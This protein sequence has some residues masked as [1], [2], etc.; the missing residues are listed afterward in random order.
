MSSTAVMMMMVVAVGLC[1]CCSGGIGT[2][3]VLVNEKIIQV[4]FLDW[5]LIGGWG[6][7]KSEEEGGE[8]GGSGDYD[9]S[10]HCIDEVMEA[11]KS[12]DAFTTLYTVDD[13]DTCVST[14]MDKCISSGG[15]RTSAIG[16]YPKDCTA[17]ARI[18]CATRRGKDR[19]ECMKPYREKCVKA[20]GTWGSTPSGS[21][22]SGSTPSGSTSTGF[23]HKVGLWFH[24]VGKARE[25]AN[26]SHEPRRDDYVERDKDYNLRHAKI[27][28][29]SRHGQSLNDNLYWI[30]TGKNV[31]AIL[32]E[33]HDKKGKSVTVEKGTFLDVQKTDLKGK[34]SYIEV[35]RA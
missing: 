19:D 25:K 23:D 31:K 30:K 28:Y 1:V 5:L 15:S 26:A 12:R 2:L 13:H 16:T 27:P 32:Y 29:P 24:G 11:C 9:S 10:S 18:H 4:D 17:G 6:K 14:T 20:G 35:V 3:V 7:E 33:H 8:G 22:P 21:T 34:V